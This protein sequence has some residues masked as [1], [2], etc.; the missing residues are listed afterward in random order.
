MPV[1]EY[2]ALNT[3]GQRTAGVLSGASEQAVLSELESRA[4]TPVSIA[5]RGER[6]PLWK[7]RI[8]TRRLA[9]TYLQLADLLR[10]G[11]PL[12]RGLRLLGNRK[13]DARLGAVFRDIS[14][15]VAQGSDL[16]EAMSR[17]PE[18]FP[19]VHVAMVRAG[20]KGGFLEQ[21]MKR[22]G[23]FVLSQAEMR[24]KV[25]GNLVYP[26]M[27]VV[28][29]TVVLTVI[30]GVFVPKFRPMYASIPNLPAVS[31]FVFAMS[32]LIANFGPWTLAVLALCVIALWRLTRRAKVRRRIAEFATRL[33][34]Y[35]PLVRSLAAARF[36]RMLGTM[37]SNGIPMLTA[38]QIAK[39]AAGNVLMEEAVARATE[40]VRSGQPLA[41]PLAES[42]LFADEVVEMISVGESANNLD[43]VLTTIAETVEARVDRMLSSAVRLLEPLL[44]VMIALVV[45]TVAAGLI[46]P[47]TQMRGGF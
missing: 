32:S 7:R 19:R 39:D 16:G 29:G 47:M 34:V 20:E 14:E 13:S 28:F 15:S 36:C 43:E 23:T 5:A 41:G 1:F 24:G 6:R 12:L 42:G 17:H 4:L 26:A 33:P 35:G 8:S 46:L 3:A 21:V 9:A 31:K 22:L 30:F 45:A 11:V 37:L 27:L 40:A 25:I 18:T 44:L 38:M 10:A 2:T